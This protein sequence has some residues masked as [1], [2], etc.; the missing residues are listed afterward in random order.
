LTPFAGWCFELT[1]RAGW[2]RDHAF[3]AINRN[4]R[5]RVSY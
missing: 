2:G 1:T 4:R 3:L 5:I